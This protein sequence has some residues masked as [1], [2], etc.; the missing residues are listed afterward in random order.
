M[1]AFIPFFI[2]RVCWVGT[3]GDLFLLL[4]GRPLTLILAQLSYEVHRFYHPATILV[5]TF[6]HHFA[7]LLHVV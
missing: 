4:H 3:V 6:Q 1:Q 5:L 7:Y 2:L